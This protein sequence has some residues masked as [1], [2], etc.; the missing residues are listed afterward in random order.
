MITNLTERNCKKRP[1]SGSQ[2]PA[3]KDIKLSEEQSLRT[4]LVEGQFGIQNQGHMREEIEISLLTLNGNKFI[5]TITPQ[6]AK[7]NIYRDTLLFGDFSNFD[8]VRFAFRGAPVVVFKLKS[9]INVDE[10]ISLQN[11][12]FRRKSSRNGVAHTDIIGCKIK[13][14]RHQSSTAS[15]GLRTGGVNPPNPAQDENIREL[16]IFGCEYRVP[17]E[18]LTSTLAHY[19]EILTDIVEELFDDGLNEDSQGTNRTGTYVVKV[20]LRKDMPELL[21]IAGRRIR[22]SFPGVRKKCTNCFGNHPKTVCQSNRLK[23]TDY[24]VNFINT[25]PDFPRSALGRW[26]DLV[27]ASFSSTNNPSVP[28]QVKQ[29]NGQHQEQQLGRDLVQLPNLNLPPPAP[30]QWQP[31]STGQALPTPEESGRSQLPG[32]AAVESTPQAPSALAVAAPVQQTPTSAPTAQIN[33][34]I[35][36]RSLVQDLDKLFHTNPITATAEWLKR[37]SSTSTIPTSLPQTSSTCTASA[38]AARTM[39]VPGDFLV[40]SN[41]VEHN[42]IIARLV[43]GGSLPAEAEQTIASRKTAFN[44]A[45]REFKKDNPMLQNNNRTSKQSKQ[46]KINQIPHVN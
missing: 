25:N 15:T 32:S 1:H 33:V 9:A 19:G 12:E 17:K 35:P 26:N 40:P 30:N 18:D 21:P 22:V 45:L 14:L 44:K 39:P 6:E 23:F 46:S 2:D 11:F 29:V 13:G 36:T 4:D 28:Q 27:G 8:G 43:S 38:P 10:L 42:L 3:P 16:R 41:L 5:G 7:F 24:V 31:D 20:K 34:G 37:Q